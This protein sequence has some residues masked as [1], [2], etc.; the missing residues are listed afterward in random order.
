MSNRIWTRSGVAWRT[1]AGSRCRLSR[2]N[3]RN[4]RR[5]PRPART[6]TSARRRA[7]APRKAGAVVHLGCGHLSRSSNDS[8]A[9]P[10]RLRCLD[11]PHTPILAVKFESRAQALPPRRRSSS[12]EMRSL[13]GK[14]DGIRPLGTVGE[15]GGQDAR[16]RPTTTSRNMSKLF[17]E[18]VLFSDGAIAGYTQLYHHLT[19]KCP[20]HRGWGPGFASTATG[21]RDRDPNRLPGIRLLVLI[22]IGRP[23]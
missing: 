2:P 9:L 8:L 12:L 13:L 17:S 18:Q 3:S 19:G 6:A 4:G 14:T 22:A 5:T 16:T 21:D 11:R 7:S 1:T 15:Y 20:D 10:G 23:E